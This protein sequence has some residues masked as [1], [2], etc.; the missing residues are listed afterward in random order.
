MSK[1]IC[2]ICGTSYPE[3]AA[4]C[5]ICG[6]V[7][8]VDT[9][10]AKNK[11]TK[12]G[13]AYTYVKGGRFSKKNVKKRNAGSPLS[14]VEIQQPNND[15]NEKE[16][17]SNRILVITIVALLLAIIA[18]GAYIAVGMFG[19]VLF[20]DLT[21]TEEK[22]EPSDA[23]QAS[24]APSIEISISPES[25]VLE[26]EGQEYRIKV[27]CT[28]AD[29][30]EV[31]QYTSD[32]PE[33][34][35]VDKT[36]KL[37]AVSEGE[38]TVTVTC[39]TAKAICTVVCTF[40]DETVV[41]PVTEFALNK[42]DFTLSA[43]GE[44]WVL[45][46][47]EIPVSEITW[48]SDDEKIATVKDGKVV[49]VGSGVTKVHAEYDG[50][51]YSCIVRCTFEDEQDVPEGE[52]LTISKTDVTLSVNESFYLTLKDASGKTVD[53]NWT[54]S[55]PGSVEISGNKITGKSTID[56]STVYTTY[57][58]VKYSCIVRVAR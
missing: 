19:D 27:T 43:K 53:V 40:P 33:V 42:E 38:A 31:V 44:S 57:E 56:Y 12:T 9:G 16:E 26:S 41:L 6:C 30:S 2:E 49:A 24:Q 39:G 51:K 13:E 1:I 55:N 11:D 17:K 50:E 5:P 15:K 54:S 14:P 4:Q 48:S 7:K 22:T 45:Y 29:T 10:S 34:V 3:T 37:T 47:G 32:A 20:P 23:D 35:T 18:V 58:G 46:D 28:P 25:V 8:P 36:G 21:A 52:K